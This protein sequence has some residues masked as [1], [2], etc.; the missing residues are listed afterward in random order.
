MTLTDQPDRPGLYFYGDTL[1]SVN[2]TKGPKM[3]G[4]GP[5][6]AEAFTID[7]N[8]YFYQSVASLTEHKWK[9]LELDRDDKPKNARARKILDRCIAAG[10]AR[11]RE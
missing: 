5:L 11:W 4:N 10:K 6:F 7:G 8:G 9:F 2:K 3:D 1:V